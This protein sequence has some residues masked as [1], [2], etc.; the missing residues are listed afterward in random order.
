MVMII[1][2]FHENMEYVLIWSDKLC[3]WRIW[4]E[5]YVVENIY[6]IE[7]SVEMLIMKWIKN[8]Y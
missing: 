2:S 8:V 7:S 3:W 6:G 4:K 1:M 5:V